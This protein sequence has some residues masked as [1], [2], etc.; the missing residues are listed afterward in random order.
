MGPHAEH[1]K[2]SWYYA[3]PIGLAM[4]GLESPPPTPDLA[5]VF[6]VQPDLSVF[7]GAGLVRETLVPLFRYG[8][9]KRIDQVTSSGWTARG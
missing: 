8:T 9:I 4:L 6:K 2:T 7:A 1:E 5:T 3:S